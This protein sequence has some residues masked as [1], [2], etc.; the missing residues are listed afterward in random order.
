LDIPK[1]FYRPC[2]VALEAIVRVE[3]SHLLAE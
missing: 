1:T 3:I 2:R